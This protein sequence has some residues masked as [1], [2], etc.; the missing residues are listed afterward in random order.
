MTQAIPQMTSDFN[1]LEDV[2][3]YGSA[4]QLARYEPFLSLISPVEIPVN[5][6]SRP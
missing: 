3:W 6:D 5:A 1:S 4:Y 2:G